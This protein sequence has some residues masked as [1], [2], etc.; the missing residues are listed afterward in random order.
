MTGLVGAAGGLGGFFPPLLMGTVQDLT[1]SYA[2]GF[3]LLSE[4]AML[5]LIV[6]LLALQR[7]AGRL[8]P[9]DEARRDDG[10][11]YSRS[12]ADTDIPRSAVGLLY[13]RIYP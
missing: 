5:A 3:M 2:I 10:G 12:V 11:G 13:L 4:F 7:Y 8:V 6:N 9:D 1:G